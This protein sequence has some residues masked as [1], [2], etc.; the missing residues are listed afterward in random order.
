MEFSTDTQDQEPA[1]NSYFKITNL[2]FRYIS[3]DGSFIVSGHV[4]RQHSFRH[5]TE[6]F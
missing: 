1:Q 5:G 4:S 3:A 6:V 2:L